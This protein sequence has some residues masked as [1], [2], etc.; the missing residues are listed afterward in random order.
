MCVRSRMLVAVHVLF[1]EEQRPHYIQ[2][3]NA[4]HECETIATSSREENLKRGRG[5]RH[6]RENVHYFCAFRCVF[7][8]FFIASSCFRV[9]GFWFLVFLISLFVFNFF[10]FAVSWG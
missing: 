4:D 9:F 6:P 7:G 8:C 1:T 5:K 2:A 3:W 10:F